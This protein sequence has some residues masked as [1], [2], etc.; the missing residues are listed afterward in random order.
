M[1]LTYSAV[2]NTVFGTMRVVTFNLTTDAAEHELGT[3]YHGLTDVISILGFYKMSGVTHM[4]C[5]CVQMNLD[6]SG[7]ASNGCLG[8]SSVAGAASTTYRVTVM[9]R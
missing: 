7:V 8:F 9:G 4:G 2:A 3:S 5:A 1:A 6:S